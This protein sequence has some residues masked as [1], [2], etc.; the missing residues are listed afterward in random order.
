M[1]SSTDTL[2]FVEQELSTEAAPTGSELH[3]RLFERLDRS[4]AQLWEQAR[5]GAL[6]THVEING[7]DLELYRLLMAQIYHYTSHNSINQAIAAFTTAPEQLRLQQFVLEHAREELGHE[8][9]VLHDLRAVGL[10]NKGESISD[11]PLAATDAL[12]N[13]LYGLALREG[14]IPRLGYSY[15]AEDVY[16]HIAPLM[17]RARETLNLQDRDMSFFVAHAE[18]DTKHADEVR[19]IIRKAVTTQE[20]A[21][22]VHRVAVTTLTLTHLLMEQTYSAWSHQG[23]ND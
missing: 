16:A 4:I 8:R 17:Q 23:T 19:D 11:T 12:I 20:Q 9:M 18:I 7:F 1:S 2:D 5:N 13:Y 15:W 14:P 3:A 21:D 6:W 22:A 10:L